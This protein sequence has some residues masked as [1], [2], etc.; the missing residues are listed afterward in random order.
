MNS[1]GAAGSLDADGPRRFAPPSQD[2]FTVERA[3]TSLPGPDSTSHENRL[4]HPRASAAARSLARPLLRT[5][6][7]G[8]CARAG[9]GLA[10]LWWLP[11]SPSGL[12]VA[13]PV[14]KTTRSRPWE[15]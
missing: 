12:L 14:A 5:G 11:R 9:S 3:G 2:A 13:A 15:A 7:G 1:R 6:M 4:A 10:W 8:A